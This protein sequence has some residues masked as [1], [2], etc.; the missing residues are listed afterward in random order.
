MKM[1]MK[2]KMTRW[3]VGKHWFVGTQMKISV[4]LTTPPQA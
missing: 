1:K 2:M 3:R 4:D